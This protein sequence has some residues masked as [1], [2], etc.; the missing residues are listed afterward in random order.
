MVD[1]RPVH[2]PG[3]A[4]AAVPR[5][6]VPAL[7]VYDLRPRGGPATTSAPGRTHGGYGSVTERAYTWPMDV[8]PRD[9][10]REPDDRSPG[11]GG[12][13]GPERLAGVRRALE[14][15]ADELRDAAEVLD[16]TLDDLE[17]RSRD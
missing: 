1:L 8:Q 16:E 2:P 5:T 15:L 17:P 13:D 11:P 9:P 3:G 4:V 12:E 14:R 7:R 10:E 6:V